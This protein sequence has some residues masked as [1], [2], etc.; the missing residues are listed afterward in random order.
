MNQKIKT[1]QIIHAG[2][3]AGVTIGYFVVGNLSFETFKSQTIT[4]DDIGFV[5]LFVS[6]FVLS[7]IVFKQQLKN[8]K[9]NQSFEEKFGIYQTASII[10]YAILEGIAFLYLFVKPNLLFLGV[11]LIA[12]LIYLRPTQARI[13]TDLEGLN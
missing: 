2:I 9:P 12:Y 4:A 5:A 3:C 7:N 13:Q 11:L 10:R 6:S 1:L 8:I